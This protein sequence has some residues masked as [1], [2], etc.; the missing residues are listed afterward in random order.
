LTKRF[1]AVLANAGLDL[2][3]EKGSIHG[4]VGENGAGKSTC[5]KMLYGMFRPDA[6]EILLNGAP[7]SFKSPADALAHGVGMVHQ[8]FMLAGPHSV[9]DNVLLGVE[10]GRWGVIDR[11]SAREKLEQ[12]ATE[13]GLRVDWSAP[14]EALPPGLQQRVEILKLLFRRAEILILDEPTAVLTPGEVADLFAS[15]RR[16]RCEGKTILLV[17]HKL[18]EVMAITDHVTVLRA[19]KSTGYLRTSETSAEHLGE[20]MVGRKVT[21]ATVVEGVPDSAE[22]ALEVDHVSLKSKTSNRM[23]LSE[24]RFVVRKGEIVGVAGIEGNGQTEL[25]E[26]LLHPRDHRRRFTG[27]IRVLGENVT[28]R[29]TAQIRELGVAV[30]PAD[31]LKDGLLLDASARD[32]FLLGFQRRPRYCRSGWLRLG[33]VETRARKAFA[34][35]N[36]QPPNPGLPSRHFSGGNQQKLVVAREFQDQ[37]R[38]VI[39]AHPTR[40]VDVG[41]VEFI[42]QRLLDARRA[43]AGVLLVSSELDEILKLSDRILVLFNGRI[44]AEFKRGEAGERELGLKM[45]GCG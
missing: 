36:V 24:V 19:G 43:G 31:R 7:V 5:M 8:H 32:T 28:L 23:E 41:A 45:G 14:V 44:A 37:P 11:K 4:V 27:Q 17:T 42:H 26:V 33:E 15:L 10:P 3:V 16:L 2:T 1:G 18:K 20:L 30:L 6:G 38:L 40:G 12:L 29:T 39:A 9:L 22:C 21:H 34:E 13:Y 35:F 25:L